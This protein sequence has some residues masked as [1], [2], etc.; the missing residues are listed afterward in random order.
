MFIEKQL[1][2]FWLCTQ[3]YHHNPPTHAWHNYVEKLE[4][5]QAIGAFFLKKSAHL[6]NEHAAAIV[7]AIA[8][9]S[10][11]GNEKC[12]EVIEYW[13]MIDE[14]R[15]MSDVFYH[16]FA[17]SYA[18]SKD[19]VSAIKY[20]KKVA[21]LG[22]IRQGY[23]EY[24]LGLYYSGLAEFNQYDTFKQSG[25][26]N[27]LST[28]WDGDYYKCKREGVKKNIQEGKKWFSKSISHG[29]IKTS[30][31]NKVLTTSDINKIIKAGGRC[32]ICGY[33]EKKYDPVEYQWVKRSHSKCFQE[34]SNR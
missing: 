13:S 33:G 17:E 27:F 5:N 29:Y 4:Y 31:M 22:G 30:P 34:Y 32:I 11:I 16:S 9:Q 2:L 18:E 26:G 20:Y 19:Y 24:M 12:N 23:A 8:E 7:G 10:M 25:F 15:K 21:E 1:N 14:N 28:S 6:G 3:T